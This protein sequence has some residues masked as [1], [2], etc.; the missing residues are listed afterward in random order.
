MER[1]GPIVVDGALF[2]DA[3]DIV[4]VNAIS[5]TMNVRETITMSKPEIVF[6]RVALVEKLIC[7]V[8]G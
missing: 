2:F 7:L 8:D 1:N 4:Q 6:G 3:E 5:C